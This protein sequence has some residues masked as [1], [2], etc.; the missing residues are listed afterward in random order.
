MGG[1]ISVRIAEQTNVKTI[2][3]G[4]MG[5]GAALMVKEDDP[6]LKL[7]Y[8]P[9]IP[10]LFLTNTSEIGQIKDYIANVKKEAEKDHTAP[11]GGDEVKVPALHLVG[12]EGHNWTNPRGSFC[13]FS[14]N[15]LTTQLHLTSSHLPLSERFRAFSTLVEWAFVGS[16]VTEYLFDGTKP[17]LAQPGVAKLENSPDGMHCLLTGPI[18]L[19]LKGRINSTQVNSPPV[20][21]KSHL[22]TKA[23]SPP[24]QRRTLIFA[25]IS[26]WKTFIVPA[27]NCTPSSRCSALRGSLALLRSRA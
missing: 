26:P 5:I 8:R 24:R 16:L 25:P 7:T 21:I 17:G 6:A 11:V 3:S 1:A 15:S 27:S 10:I 23:L 20:R 12:R 19:Q 4:V 2:F 22:L 13:I 18:S 14:L 9:T